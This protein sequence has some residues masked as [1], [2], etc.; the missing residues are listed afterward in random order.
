MPKLTLSIDLDIDF[1]VSVAVE[2]FGYEAA[3]GVRRKKL[4]RQEPQMLAKEG[5]IDLS[6]EDYSESASEESSSSEE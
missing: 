1:R 4:A 6:P 2:A 3:V 5:T